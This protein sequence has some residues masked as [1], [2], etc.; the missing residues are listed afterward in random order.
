SHKLEEVLALA[1]RTAVLRDGRL[2][3]MLSCKDTTAPELGRMM[4]GRDVQFRVE[5]K[6][7][8]P[9]EVLLSV[10]D[11]WVDDDRALPALRGITID[12]RAGEIVGIAGVE[13]NGQRELEQALAGLRAI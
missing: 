4:V 6:P 1:D 7:A 5:K 11:L 2:V 12:V 9:G 13:G 10:H 3:G 8:Q